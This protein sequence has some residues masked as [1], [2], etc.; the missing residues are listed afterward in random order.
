MLQHRGHHFAAA[1]TSQEWPVKKMADVNLSNHLE[2]SI[3][4][5]LPHSGC[6]LAGINVPSP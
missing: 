1:P 4:E 2:C 5:C 3:V 6:S